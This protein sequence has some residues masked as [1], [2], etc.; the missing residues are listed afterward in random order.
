MLV[1]LLLVLLLLGLTLPPSPVSEEPSFTEAWHDM[2]K[3]DMV[4][5]M[6]TYWQCGLRDIPI[7]PDHVPTMDGESNEHPGYEMLGRLWALGYMK[8]LMESVAHA[9]VIKGSFRLQQSP[10]VSA[11][12]PAAAP[13]AAL[14]PADVLSQPAWY[15]PYAAAGSHHEHAEDA[16]ESSLLGAACHNNVDNVRALLAAGITADSS[17]EISSQGYSALMAACGK[18]HAV[19]AAAL[20]KGGA[21]VNRRSNNGTTA[22]H[23]AAGWGHHACC[24]LLLAAG[25]DRGSVN[26]N[27]ETAQ[28]YAN[29]DFDSEGNGCAKLIDNFKLSISA[30]DVTPKKK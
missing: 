27:G 29:D 22:L 14:A 24:K 11:A 19:V 26:D 21:N 16:P 8:G 18:G 6:A 3:T 23:S 7:R 12:A 10:V 1:L 25:A 17:Q 15:T 5:A 9:S 2:G 4:T 28:D 13:A 30:A 20:I